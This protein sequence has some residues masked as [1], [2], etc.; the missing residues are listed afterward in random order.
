MNLVP[1]PGVESTRTSPRCA[2]TARCTMASPRPLPPAR[3]E[4]N[5]SKRRSDQ[6]GIDP[7]PVIVDDQLDRG[8]DV[9]AGREIGRDAAGPDGDGRPCPCPCTACTA[10]SSRLLTTRCSRSSSASM[11]VASPSHLEPR[12]RRTAVGMLPHQPGGL[13]RHREEVDRRRSDRPD[14]REIK[15]FSEQP[16]QPVALAHDQPAQGPLIVVAPAPTA[17]A[18]PPSSGSTRAGSG[19]RARA[20]R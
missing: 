5:G 16:A 18:A 12:S 13:R 20:T 11:S 6:V 15:E 9:G 2:S 17:R 4:T 3:R 8:L 14:P 19:S 7:G 10:L 1:L